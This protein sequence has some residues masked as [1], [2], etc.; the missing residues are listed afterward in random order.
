MPDETYH[1]FPPAHFASK[2]AQAK[3]SA[4]TEAL[5]DLLFGSFAG[6]AGK[7]I[8]YPF[9]TVKVRLQSQPHHLPLQ[10]TGPLDCFRWSLRTGGFRSLYRGVSAPIAG[11]AAENA[12]LFGSYTVA[13]R[14]LRAEEE[15]ELTLGWK[16]V[17]G[18][19][20][21]ALTSLILTPIELVK[22]RMQ[23]SPQ[24][25]AVHS[26]FTVIRDVFRQEG[27][28]GFWRGHIGTFFRETGG[29]AAWFGSYEFCTAWFRR[30]IT[31]AT[32]QPEDR[33]VTIPIAQQMM[34]GAAAGATYNFLFYPADTIKSTMQTGELSQ[35]R[36]GFATV[37][38]ELWR[39]HGLRGLYRGCGI[40][41][42]R[43]IPSSAFIFAIVENLKAAF[44]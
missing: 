40:T 32:D 24:S 43:S 19:L 39:A 16:T 14:F 10:F 15:M 11:A 22:C 35:N 44:P 41:V 18:G 23:Y 31:A 4:S 21:G 38:R 12:A 9:D 5:R 30:R 13:Q 20:S 6:C 42:A 7:L 25:R 1:L 34:S 8:E 26:P 27:I 17:A 37:G 28:L 29:T 2:N 3:H 36:P 33:V